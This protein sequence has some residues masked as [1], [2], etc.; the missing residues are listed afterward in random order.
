MARIYLNLK[1]L[2]RSIFKLI[3]SWRF[4]LQNKTLNT[5]LRKRL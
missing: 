3:E 1:G 5:F 2:L 4:L